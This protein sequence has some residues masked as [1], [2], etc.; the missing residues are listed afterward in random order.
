ME[1]KEG[2]LHE[3]TEIPVTVNF[4]SENGY[5]ALAHIS[6]VMYV[7][8]DSGVCV[9]RKSKHNLNFVSNSEE[10]AGTKNVDVSLKVEESPKVL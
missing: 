6:T 2:E 10:G 7:C 3:T 9:K 5:S 4:P 8:L 1:S